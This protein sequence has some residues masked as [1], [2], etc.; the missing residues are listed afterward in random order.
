LSN[1]NSIGCHYRLPESKPNRLGYQPL[2]PV[3][4]EYTRR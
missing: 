4:M 1:Q 2:V 3:Q